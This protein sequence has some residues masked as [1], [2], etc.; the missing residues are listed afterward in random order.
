MEFKCYT[1]A[2]IGQ[3]HEGSLGIAH[4]YIDSVAKAGVNAVKFQMH[5]AEAESSEFEQFRIQFSYEDKTRYDY[6]KRME[7]S[8]EQ[9]AGLKQHATEVGLD[10]I[11]SP[12]SVLAVETLKK[13]G[14][15]N[16]KI[17]SGEA[18]NK[19]LLDAVSKIAKNIILSNGLINDQELDTSVSWIIAKNKN[20]SLLQCS[21]KYP[22]E[23][24]DWNLSRINYL[25]RRY[26]IPVGFSDHSGDIF[27]CIAAC[28][29]DAEI[30]EFH[31]VYD[32][33]MFGPD[34]SSS[35]T[36]K[37]VDKLISA[38]NDIVTAKN[39]LFFVNENSEVLRKNFGKSLCVNK[40]KSIGDIINFEDLET[41]KP[42]GL[43]ISS[44]DY[45]RVVGKT[46]I[47]D[48]KKWNFLNE[49]DLSK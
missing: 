24:K 30:L 45:E 9:W 4:S 12:F 6:W 17:G 13:I 3:A 8:T 27:A 26:N 21:T 33:E 1:I 35:I 40:D 36:I 46:L 15:E 47:R 44:I 38:V 14:V 43:G 34:S 7:F 39:S 28:A 19:L 11:C 42:F 2:E 48:L 5:I 32:K 10:F 31:V 23:P 37:E 16:F 22:S 41:K 29:L 18:N 49:S 25:K 20:L